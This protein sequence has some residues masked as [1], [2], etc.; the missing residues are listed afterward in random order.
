MVRVGYKSETGL[1]SWNVEH[2]RLSSK[3]FVS[4]S[5]ANKYVF[6]PERDPFFALAFSIGV[7]TGLP[8]CLCVG[9]NVQRL[10][11]NRS[12]S[13]STKARRNFRF[14]PTPNDPAVCVHTCMRAYRLLDNVV[15]YHVYY[16]TSAVVPRRG[17]RLLCRH[18]DPVSRTIFTNS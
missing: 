14:R 16:R 9:K 3:T 17:V 6:R 13:I 11:V 10:V 7:S 5:M 12:R 15:I 18:P 4:S 2:R 1:T 8:R